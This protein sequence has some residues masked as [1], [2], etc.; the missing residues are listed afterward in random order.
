MNIDVYG[1]PVIVFSMS[2]LGVFFA[3]WLLDGAFRTRLMMSEA[4]WICITNAGLVTFLYMF[5]KDDFP[6]AVNG[7]IGGGLAV[8]A[9]FL[10]EDLYN[11]LLPRLLHFL[12]GLAVVAITMVVLE[13]AGTTALF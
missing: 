8:L 4:V 5:T 9:N 10:L 13:L 7:L 12:Q 6:V 1:P 11:M 2:V 3:L